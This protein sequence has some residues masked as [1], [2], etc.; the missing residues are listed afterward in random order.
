MFITGIILMAAAVNIGLIAFLPR[1]QNMIKK[2]S[3]GINFFLT[4]I[5]TLIGV[6]IAIIITEYEAE[7]KERTDTIKLLISSRESVNISLIYGKALIEKHK[8]KPDF[9]TH[10]PLP[11]PKYLDVLLAQNI[12]NRNLSLHS[13]KGLNTLVIHLDR[14]KEDT[15]CYV[16]L[17]DCTKEVIG[18]EIK[19]LSK[20]ISDEEIKQSMDD[21]I[22]KTGSFCMKK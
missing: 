18:L 20:Q 8:D 22:K 2:Y 4:L 11:Y 12:I 19:Y 21:L 10:S 5:A 9:F 17:L 16:R 14:S 3:V 1:Y 15:E 13:L 6:A 7:R